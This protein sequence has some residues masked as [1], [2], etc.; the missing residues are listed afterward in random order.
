[1]IGY[2]KIPE[3]WRAGIPALADRKFAY[4]R[5]S[6]DEIVRSTIRRAEKVVESVGGK[7]TAEGLEVPRQ[8]PEPAK[9]EQWSP[10][11]PMKRVSTADPAWS[12]K[13]AWSDGSMDL[14]GETIPNKTTSTAGAEATFSF[15]GTGVVLAGV[16]S[17]EGGRAH[18]YVDGQDA[19]GAEAWIPE[20]THDNALWHVY[21][22]PAGKHT[23]RL[24]TRADA[25]LRSKGTR[26][27]LDWAIVYGAR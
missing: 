22:L 13:G 23:V 10:G 14:W 1:M 24:V 26:I 9:L 20:R 6:F 7:V 8:E 18:V 21:G 12:W 16:C 15:E 4:T 3:L 11:A 2:D 27:R 17:Q 19:S 25:D 5:Y